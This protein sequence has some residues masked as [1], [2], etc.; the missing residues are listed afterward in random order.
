[1]RDPNL[2]RDLQT[3]FN[4]ELVVATQLFHALTSFAI[5]LIG[6]NTSCWFSAG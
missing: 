4:S 1:M 5:I 2:G 6:L 3:I